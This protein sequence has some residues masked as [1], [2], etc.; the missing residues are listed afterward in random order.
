MLFGHIVLYDHTLFLMHAT[1]FVL[2]LILVL[3][4]YC[5]WFICWYVCA[6][7][8]GYALTDIYAN[9]DADTFTNVSRYVGKYGNPA[10]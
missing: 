10:L 6:D 5:C 1:S 2:M 4:P 8:S 7:N 9:T 3:L